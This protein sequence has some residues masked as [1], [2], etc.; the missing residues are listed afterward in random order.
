VISL[1]IPCYNEGEVLALS[2]RALADAA[3]AWAEP[4]EVIFVDDGSDDNTWAVIERLAGQDGRV[5]GVRLSRN[6]GHQAAIGAGLEHAIGAA[7]V[8][9][10]ADLQDPPKLIGDMI[11]RWRDGFDVVAARRRRRAGVG[12]VKR[13]LGYAFYRLLARVTHV[14]VPTDTGDFALLDRRVV[15]VMLGCRE[16]A[17]FWRG[18]RCFAGFRHTVVG[19]ER[20]SRAAGESKYTLRKLA[21]L[22]SNGVL[23]FSDAPLRIGLYAGPALFLAAGLGAC[24]LVVAWASNSVPLL[25]PLAVLVLSLAGL[26]MTC[27]GVMG[28]YMNRLYAE[29]RQRPRWVVSERIGRMAQ[30]T[31]RAAGRPGLVSRGGA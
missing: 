17:L 6:F 16:Q 20:P 22:A 2:Y 30:P 14:S 13:V 24:G 29:V 19:F 4:V 21:G 25:S 9:L 1:V 18:L 15:D 26:Q 23:S 10:D 7:V 31:S 8:V 27:L 11:A 12:A 5:R 28:E 3:K